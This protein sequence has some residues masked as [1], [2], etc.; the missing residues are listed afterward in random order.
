MPH[1]LSAPLLDVEDPVPD[2]Y[3]LEVS[4]PGID[5][6]IERPEDF[7]R[8]SGFR[9]KVKLME[10]LEQERKRYTG[11]IEGLEDGELLLVSGEIHHRISLDDVATVRLSPTP[12]DYDRLREVSLK[13]RPDDQ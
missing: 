6:L 1:P 5:R 11:V 10:G 8:F 9:A 3:N 4:S 13:E 7:I 12:E 2:N